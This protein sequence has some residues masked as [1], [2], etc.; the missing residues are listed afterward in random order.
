MVLPCRRKN[1]EIELSCRLKTD[2][3]LSS[4]I[5]RWVIRGRRKGQGGTESLH[6]QALLL[7]LFEAALVA[8]FFSVKTDAIV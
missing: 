7:E 5:W 8:V 1:I 3:G 2:L 4:E 6:I